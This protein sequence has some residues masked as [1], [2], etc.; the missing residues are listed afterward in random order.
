MGRKTLELHPSRRRAVVVDRRFGHLDRKVVLRNAIECR[1][2]QLRRILRFANNRVE[3]E[4]ILKSI[5]PD[6]LHILGNNHPFQL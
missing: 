5:L 2:I 1:R 6:K 3:L 4:T